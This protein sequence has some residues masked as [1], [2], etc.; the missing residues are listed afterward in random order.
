M[1][2]DPPHLP[3]REATLPRQLSGG[4]PVGNAAAVVELVG[5]QQHPPEP[6]QPITE[7]PRPRQLLPT[8]NVVEI[9]DPL[10]PKPRPAGAR[11]QPAVMG[12][13][14]QEFTQRQQGGRQLNIPAPK[15]A[16]EPAPVGWS[17]GM[18][19]YLNQPT[20]PGCEMCGAAR[21]DNYVIPPN[22]QL[23]EEEQR[24]L[25]EEQRQAALVLQVRLCY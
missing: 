12:Q 18:C 25:E 20:R 4:H 19:T 7:L 14:A 6:I 24:R 17:C 23:T 11:H 3:V 2:R 9:Q 15:P 22:Y 16:P 21:P 13:L 10:R 8:A 1:R 5:F